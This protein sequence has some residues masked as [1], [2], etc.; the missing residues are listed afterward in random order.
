MMRRQP[1]GF[2]LIELLVVIAIIAVLIA[3]LLPAV[4]QAREAG[5]RTQCRNNL[6]QMGIA[7]HNYQDTHGC[8][9]PGWIY[10]GC[11]DTVG[12]ADGDWS[13]FAMLMP[14]LDE[15]ALF[16]ATN[17]NQPCTSNANSTMVRKQLAQF[18]C[19]SHRSKGLDTFTSGLKF[20]GADFR[21]NHA[22]AERTDSEPVTYTNG[23]SNG[24]SQCSLTIS[25]AGVQ[26]GLSNTI[27]VGENLQGHWAR[28]ASCCIATRASRKIRH[29][30]EPGPRY[31]WSSM[32]PD[33]AVFLFGDGSAK[34]ISDTVDMDVLRAL[35]TASGGEAIGD[36]DF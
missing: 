35:M 34:F 18:F 10:R 22:A 17:F 8:F 16:N 13:G 23:Q 1:V 19:P 9:P 6:H 36:T 15:R 30:T 2:T 26:D 25:E 29:S 14:Y 21:W 24:F 20:S 7:L 4:Q 32:H 3:L 33:G 11:P 12:V 28:G 31:T 5:R 27:A